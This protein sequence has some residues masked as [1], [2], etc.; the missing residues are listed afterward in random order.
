MIQKRYKSKTRQPQNDIKTTQPKRIDI[1]TN[2]FKTLKQRKMQRFTSLLLTIVSMWGCCV[3]AVPMLIDNQMGSFGCTNDN[4]ICLNV[5]DV[6]LQTPGAIQLKVWSIISRHPL[7]VSWF[8][9]SLIFPNLINISVFFAPFLVATY[10]GQNSWHAV[11]IIH[12]SDTAEIDQSTI[13][14]SFWCFPWSL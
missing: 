12:A 5:S 9:L 4:I 3:Y 2:N 1:S 8:L 13:R 6:K 11:H 14:Y 10:I 7:T